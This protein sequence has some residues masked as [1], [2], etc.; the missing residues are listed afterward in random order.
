MG[1]Y[2]KDDDLFP[3]KRKRRKIFFYSSDDESVVVMISIKCTKIDY[4]YS[5]RSSLLT[6]MPRVHERWFF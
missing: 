1:E 6:Y 2:D 4:V 5:A 3:P